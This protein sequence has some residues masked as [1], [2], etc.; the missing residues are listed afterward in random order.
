M[1]NEDNMV[2]KKDYTVSKRINLPILIQEKMIDIYKELK[3]SSFTELLRKIYDEYLED[4]KSFKLIHSTKLD[5]K[6][7][8]KDVR[9]SKK[10]IDSIQK[11][12]N[13]FFNGNYSGFTQAIIKGWFEKNNFDK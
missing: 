11:N 9:L 6:K 13:R 10:T 7:K 12:A 1:N 8:L 4:P 2:D 3:L 5:G